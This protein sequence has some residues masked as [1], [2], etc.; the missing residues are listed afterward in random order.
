MKSGVSGDLAVIIMAAGKGMRM[1]SDLAKV[2]HPLHGRAMIHYVVETAQKLG[3]S[4]IVIIVGHQKERVMAELDGQPV[5]FAVQE[6]QLGTGHAIM[7]A[8]PQLTPDNELVLILSGDVPLIRVET[9]K[10]LVGYHRQNGA[11]ATVLTA[12]TDQPKGYGRIVRQSSG[13]LAAIIEERDASEEIKRIDEI[14]SG[15]YVFNVEDL[16]ATL[17][18]LQTDN[19]QKEYYQTDAVRLLASSGRIVAAFEGDFREVRGI[20][21]VAELADANRELP[22]EGTV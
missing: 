6:P 18:K 13:H 15:I 7:C 4:P 11:A 20:N 16:R 22:S 8:L 2:M 12:R 10:N 5:R 17:P 21:T 9:L 14:N 19:D 1:K 3:A